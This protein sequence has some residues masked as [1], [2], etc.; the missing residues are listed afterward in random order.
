MGARY[1]KVVVKKAK[2]HALI[3]V[4]HIESLIVSFSSA[5]AEH[6][7][8]NCT[9]LIRQAREKRGFPRERSCR[10]FAI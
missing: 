3:T 9:I 6:F 1:E 5:A 2:L 4:L 10:T 8:G 7:E